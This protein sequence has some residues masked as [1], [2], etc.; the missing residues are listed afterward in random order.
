MRLDQLIKIM[1]VL[2]W[3][4][5]FGGLIALFVFVVTLFH[6]NREIAVQAAPQLFVAFERYHLILAGIALL[7]TVLWR[8]VVRLSQRFAKRLASR[9]EDLMHE[10]A[11]RRRVGAEPVVAAKPNQRRLDLR[12]RP[13]CLRRQTAEE[14]DAREHLCHD[15]QRTISIGISS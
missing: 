12:C 14:L 2:S 5:W 8:I 1:L 7:A 11:E 13:E 15:G 3:A 6:N 10:S 9:G 4:L